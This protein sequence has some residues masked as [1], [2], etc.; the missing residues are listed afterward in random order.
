M[1]KYYWTVGQAANVEIVVKKS[2]FIAF[3]CPVK[4]EDEAVNFINQIKSRHKDATHNVPAFIV[5]IEQR[6]QRCS[7]DG[8]PSGTAGLP[9]LDV[10][11]RNELTNV[12]VVVTRY[13]GG[14]K[15]GK[16]GLIRAYSQAAQQGIAAARKQLMTLYV[17]LSVK[18]DYSWIGIIERETGQLNCLKGKDKFLELVTLNYYVPIEQREMLHKRI[19]NATNDGVDLYWGD[20]RYLH[21][22]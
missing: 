4:D 9:V 1:L 21:N 14:F 22:H 11:K 15:L 7:D 3:L 13:F 19:I 12:A 17:E 8:E 6:K 20:V 5:G 10:L 18:T 2:R 16:G